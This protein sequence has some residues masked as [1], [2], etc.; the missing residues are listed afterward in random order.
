V[1]FLDIPR[2]F[3]VLQEHAVWL[4]PIQWIPE[5]VSAR[6]RQLESEADHSSPCVAEVMNAVP[7]LPILVHGLVL[8]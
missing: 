7:P 8:N 5:T 4:C 3:F 1:L 6:V 2:H